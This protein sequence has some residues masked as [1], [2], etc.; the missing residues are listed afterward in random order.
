MNSFYRRACIHAHSVIAL[1]CMT[2]LLGGC[3][4]SSRT[5]SQGV[6]RTS[7]GK[8]LLKFWNGFTGPDGKAMEQMV[9]RFKKQNP[10]VTV[11]MQIIPWGTYY[12][13]LTLAL[14][15]GGAPDVFVMHASR[16]PGFAAYDAFQPLQQ[17]FASSQPPLG[18]KDFASVPWQGTFY[19]DQQ[20]AMPLDVHPIGLFYNTRLF[21]EAGIVDAE[22]NAKPPKNLDEFLDAAKRLTKDTNGD[23]RPDQWGFVYTWQRT[24]WLTFAGQFGASI[25]SPDGSQST[26]SA[27][28]NL[29][30]LS[31]MHDLIY[32]HKVAP[33]PEGVDA[34]LAFRQ[35]KVG[36]TLEGIYML[37]SLEEQKGLPFAGAPAPQFGPKQAVWGGSHLLCQPRGITPEQ[38]QAAW[39]LMRFLSDDSLIW[40]RAG[41]VPARLDTRNS[42]QFK[43]LEV[44]SQFAKQLEYVQY[45]PLH[46]KSD[47]F[48]PL[49]EPALES[50]LL[51]ISTPEEAMRDASRRV[52]QLLERQ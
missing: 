13:K 36:M 48:F 28:E 15:Y 35:G 24:N 30:A 49:I 45:E 23:K 50:V 32:K 29:R 42:P 27:P 22:G 43:A 10:D 33:K 47:A 38:S 40:A 8:I 31:L 16:L 46:P 52:N 7:D 1:L 34:W 17:H 51:N 14:A 19:K 18:A 37:T 11:Q 20:Y 44:Q 12:D 5:P 4:S 39:R 2:F 6:T 26:L 25:L 21:K 3:D 41:Q 9:A